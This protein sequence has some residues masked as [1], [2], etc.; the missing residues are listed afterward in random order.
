MI[1]SLMAALAAGL[2]LWD[3]KEKTKYVDQLEQLKKDYYAEYEKPLDQR[4]DDEL[5]RI[6]RELCSAGHAFA[7]AVTAK[8]A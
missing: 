5:S 7:A 3:G 1:A 2:S 8:S 6:E 4:S